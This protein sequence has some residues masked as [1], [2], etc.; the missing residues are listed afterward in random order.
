[1]KITKLTTYLLEPRWLFLKIETD[2]GISGWGEP[3]V[4]GKA[5]SVQA[6]IDDLSTSLI[7]KNPLDI[8]KIWIELYRGGF[9]RG[10]ATH[11]SAM[12]GIDQALW[13]IKG[14]YHD[15]PI[16]ELLGGK[17]RDKQKV[18]SWVH[19]YEFPTD[20]DTQLKRARE[21]GI[22]T[23]KT[24]P[25][26]QMDFI[27]THKEID[28]VIA[29]VD[30]IHSKLNGEI[31]LALDFHGR[32]HRGT[33]K[34]LLKELEHFNLAFIE[35]PVLPEHLD[36]LKNISSFI[37]TPIATGERIFSRY[38]FKE[39]LQGG[40]V[41][42]IQPDLSHCGGISEGL[43][44]ASMAEA[45]DVAVAF[46]CPLGPLTMASSLQLDAVNLNAVVQEQSLGIHEYKEKEILRY[47]KN[48]EI[49]DIKDGYMEFSKKPGL[50]IEINEEVVT[51]IA[52]NSPHNWKSPLWNNTDGSFAEW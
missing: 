31:D 36:C 5:H 39:I 52:T 20:L 37:S 43:K 3:I 9:Y 50:G 38:S 10:G 12:A 11:M 13:D 8:N 42:I 45:Y 7:G 21:S 14:K 44:I 32:V 34:I 1:M 29:K 41:D 49:Y 19:P 25:S 23:V 51:E 6:M 17:V 35:E 16:Y 30:E 22:T 4:E 18:Y 24:T 27:T 15:V 46:H 48:P 2:E 33:A 47:V 40:Y 28:K 26:D